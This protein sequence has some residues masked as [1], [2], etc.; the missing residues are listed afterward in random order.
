MRV[1]WMLSWLPCATAGVAKAAPAFSPASSPS[2]T[3]PSSTLPSSTLPSSILSPSAPE[4]RRLLVVPQADASSEAALE[5]IIDVLS[6]AKRYHIQRLEALLPL[7]RRKDQARQITTA[8]MRGNQEARQA[9]LALDWTTA[10][11][12]L[13][14]A[15]KLC[16]ASFLP[17]YDPTRVANLHV[18]RG[19]V[20]LQRAQ[21][22]NARLHFKAALHLAPQ[23]KLNAFHSPQVRAA[24]AETR[25]NLPARPLP[26]PSLLKRIL[27]LAGGPPEALVLSSERK[28]GDRVLLKATLFHFRSAQLKPLGTI[29]T[30]TKKGMLEARTT[31]FGAALREQIAALYPAL[32]MVS[33]KPSPAT[34]PHTQ[35]VLPLPTPWYKRWYVWVAA[36]TALVAGAVAI[37]LLTRQRVVDVNVTW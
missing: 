26:S 28:A 37:P 24:V 21:P 12:R 11:S 23:L 1:L 20:A 15:L 6:G 2:S 32:P 27:E 18:M 34:L 10:T 14:E 8:L 36:G 33:L 9:M 17:L 31:K 3:L 16:A 25:T 13:D 19:T 35:P 7:M 22:E 29:S 5:A 4:N 30:P